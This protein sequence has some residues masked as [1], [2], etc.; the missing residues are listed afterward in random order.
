MDA[1]LKQPKIIQVNVILM[2]IQ[3]IFHTKAA[4]TVVLQTLSGFIV[5]SLSSIPA[6]NTNNTWYDS[7]DC[8]KT[9]LP[10]NTLNCIKI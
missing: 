10:N 7:N 3:S 5:S 2:S 8:V 9:P 6:F 4:S 1:V